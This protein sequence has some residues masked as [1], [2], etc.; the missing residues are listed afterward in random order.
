MEQ[1]QENNMNNST[2]Q[3]DLFELIQNIQNKLNIQDSTNK[4]NTDETAN[5]QQKQQQTQ[6][7]QNNF[8]FSKLS[9]ILSNPN[10][11]NMLNGLKGNATYN[12][13]K[14]INEEDSQNTNEFNIDINT[15]LK[16]Q[17]VMASMNK[18]DPRKNLLI[19]L[20]P[21]LRKSRQDKI[22]EYITILS[23]S[24]AFEIFSEKG[25]D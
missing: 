3:N 16:L 25:S 14:E 20:K 22:N 9:N 8:D 23:L 18:K 24:N 6:E 1:N 15:I 17:K 5:T 2:T 4:E 12:E 13:K 21:F 11:S 19:S 10:I 7:N